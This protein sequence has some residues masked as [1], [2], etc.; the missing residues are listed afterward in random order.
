MK[1]KYW[2]NKHYPLKEEIKGLAVNQLT[3]GTDL[4]GKNNQGQELI[5][6]LSLGT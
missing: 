2:Q 1:E 6:C 5:L 4:K 3:V